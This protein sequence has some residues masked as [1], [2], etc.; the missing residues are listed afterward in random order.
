MSAALPG[1]SVDEAAALAEE[2]P[3]HDFLNQKKQKTKK[4]QLKKDTG[5]CEIDDAAL[6]KFV[7]NCII[8]NN[9]M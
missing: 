5:V 8:Q 9:I 3:C 7:Y 6:V 4:K 1:P 2:G